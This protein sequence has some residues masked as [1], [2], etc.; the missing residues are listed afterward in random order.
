MTTQPTWD[1][2]SCSARN[3]VPAIYLKPQWSGGTPTSIRCPGCGDAHRFADGEVHERIGPLLIPF[4]P[5]YRVSPWRHSTT[6][7]ARPGAYL[8]RFNTLQDPILLAW[9]GQSF[10]DREKRPVRTDGLVGWRGSWSN[11]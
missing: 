9:D 1:C 11:S 8:C 3:A 10:R 2:T 7:P 5:V 6:R 4:H